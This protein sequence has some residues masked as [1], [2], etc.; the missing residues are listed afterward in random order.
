MMKKQVCA[1]VLMGVGLLL[2]AASAR[3]QG[4]FTVN[5]LVANR[6]GYGAAVIDPNLINPWGMSST[7]ASPWWSSNNGTGTTTL[8]NGAGVK[9][10]LTVTIPLPG[11]G[12]SSPTGQLANLTAADF[13][14]PTGGKSTFIF[15]TQDGT[16]AGWNGAQGATAVTKVDRS[17]VGAVYTG[18][19]S[20]ASGGSNFL[21]AADFN[22]NRIDVFNGTFGLTSLAGSFVD[23]GL[24][25]DYSPFNIQNLGGQLYVTYAQQD[26]LDHTS[27]LHGAGLGFVSIFDTNGNF[28]KRLASGGPLNA[29]WGVALAPSNFGDFSNALLVGQFGS[30]NILAY[31]PTTSAFLGALTDAGGTP[32]TIDGLWALSFG[33]G[34]NAGAKNALYYTAG[35]NNETDGVF[36]RLSFTAPEPGSMS[37]LVV[38]VFVGGAVGL[39]RRRA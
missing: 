25:A 34:A 28:V 13:A 10:A 12:V 2:G 26:P 23:P 38:G 7:A 18:L 15:A 8:Y 14:L 19:A 27:E 20:G 36:G 6:A 9:Q 37:L 4:T 31:N 30:G 35:P 39:R 29:P 21:Y 33:N 32:I 11:G 22:N 1:A 16:I 5:N 24:P 17:G 3:A